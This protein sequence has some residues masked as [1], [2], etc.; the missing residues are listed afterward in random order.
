MS[1][2]LTDEQ[3]GAVWR[4]LTKIACGRVQ[5]NNQRLSREAAV[6]TAREACDAIGW[7]YDGKTVNAIRHGETPR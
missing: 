3:Y 1:V 2:T 5:P 4:A 7:R 6:T